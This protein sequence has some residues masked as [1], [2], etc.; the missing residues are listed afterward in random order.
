M[1]ELVRA[2][3]DFEHIRSL[4][5]QEIALEKQLPPHKRYTVSGI[6]KL[7]WSLDGDGDPTFD[8]LDIQVAEKYRRKLLQHFHPDK[9]TGDIEKFNLTKTAVSMCN[10]ELL[11]FLTLG[12][13]HPIDDEDIERYYGTSFQKLAKLKAG[14]SYRAACLVMT[15]NKH[16][17]TAMVQ[18]EIDK[19]AKLIQVAILTRSKHDEETQN[20]EA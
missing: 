14:F 10:I 17:A 1:S 11:A 6:T 13:G 7:R 4:E 15:G 18:A 8:K 12:I 16:K 9:P 20:A 19:R 2:T 5:A 3:N